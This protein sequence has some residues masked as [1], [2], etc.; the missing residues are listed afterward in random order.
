MYS[1]ILTAYKEPNSVAQ[2]LQYLANPEFSGYKGKL[3]I[4]QVSPDKE[5]LEAA[6]SYMNTVKNSSIGFL[7]LIDDNLGKPHALNQALKKVN[8]DV[9]IM[10]D[11]DVR[12][13]KGSLGTLIRE[14]ENR[15]LDAGTG[16]P[17]SSN[18][19]SSFMGFISHLMVSAAHHK[20]LI[21]LEGQKTGHGSKFINRKGFF[22]LSGYMLIFNKTK[23]ENELGEGFVF[24]GDC[25]VEDAYISHV[26]FNK[27]MKLGYIPEATVL[28]KFPTNI[29]DYFIQKKRSTGGFIQLW[30]YGVVTKNTKSRSFWQDLEYFWFP[31]KFSKNLIEYLY[32]IAYFPLRLIL[33]LT[34]WWERKIIKKDFTKTWQ[35]VESTK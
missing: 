22:P 24:P 32:S 18:N 26:M 34:I 23:F 11:G 35:R 8:S 5:T 4:I 27:G 7:Q 2:A 29:K 21:E 3:N 28:V 30:K 15:K 14:F 13:A 6:K 12:F 31:F 16:Q 17:I 10:T 25:L 33:W 19:R 20:R 1:I 9:V